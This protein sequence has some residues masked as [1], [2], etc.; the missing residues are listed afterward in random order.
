[1]S[2]FVIMATVFNLNSQ[3]ICSITVIVM[4]ISVY[5]IKM[6]EQKSKSG[7]LPEQLKDFKQAIPQLM[8]NPEAPLTNN[9]EEKITRVTKA[10][11]KVSGCFRSEN[12]R[13]NIPCNM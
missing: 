9:Q 4:N 5:R 3:N 12:R 7:N 13:S 10:H 11:Q 6:G 8:I 2:D 1:M